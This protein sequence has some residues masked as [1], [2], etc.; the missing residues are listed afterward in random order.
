MTPLTHPAQYNQAT[1]MPYLRAVIQESLRLCPPLAVPMSRYVPIGG[2]Q[3]SGGY[4]PAGFRVR[5][6]ACLLYH[7]IANVF[8]GW[9]ECDG[10]A[11]QRK[12]LW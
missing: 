2:L 12:R 8:E 4:I 7:K 10:N 5:G 6:R 9:H 3:L 1:K 11:I